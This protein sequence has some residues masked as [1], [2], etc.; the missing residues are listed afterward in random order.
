MQDFEFM[1]CQKVQILGLPW[2]FLNNLEY[3]SVDN[4]ELKDYFQM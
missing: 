3:H 1:A 4:L 2:F